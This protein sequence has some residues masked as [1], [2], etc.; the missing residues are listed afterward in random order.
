MLATPSSGRPGSADTPS[1]PD[2]LET[3]IEKRLSIVERA[4]RLQM[5]LGASHL[6]QIEMGPAAFGVPSSARSSVRQLRRD[7][8]KALHGVGE[9]PPRQRQS[10]R[11][12][13]SPVGSSHASSTVDNLTGFTQATKPLE[14]EATHSTPSSGDDALRQATKPQRV[15][16]GNGLDEAMVDEADFA[17][18]GGPFCGQCGSKLV[19]EQVLDERM[20]STPS[21]TIS[22]KKP[23][24]PLEDETMLSRPSSEKPVWNC[25]KPTKTLEEETM[26]STPSSVI[27]GW[28]CPDCHGL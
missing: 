21:T 25:P 22:A 19:A 6:L 18:W 17:F 16:G 2:G 26:L 10:G 28:I 23:A 11:L 27:P 4:I 3:D 14:E 13:A 5:A 1:H 9:Q 20:Q 15:K 12:S 8:N 7:R 24:K